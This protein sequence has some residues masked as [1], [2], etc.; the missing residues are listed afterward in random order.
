MRG[1]FG[2]RSIRSMP[3]RGTLTGYTQKISALRSLLANPAPSTTVDDIGVTQVQVSLNAAATGTPP[4]A[5]ANYTASTIAD[6]D[7]TSTSI[8]PGRTA[9][10]VIAIV[11]G[12]NLNMDNT[13]GFF[14]N[15]MNGTI[16]AK[17]TATAT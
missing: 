16:G 15:A 11:T 17:I 9:T 13:G 8:A 6:A 5:P 14:P 2:C 12:G 1:W 3:E 7:I 4:V 10:Q